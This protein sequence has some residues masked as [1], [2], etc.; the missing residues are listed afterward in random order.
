MLSSVA[1]ALVW[2]PRKVFGRMR[3]VECL[4]LRAMPVLATL[5]FVFAQL[6]PA[7]A[8][9]HAIERFGRFTPWSLGLFASTWA[10]AVLSVAGVVLAL[11][12]RNRQIRR[13]VWWHGFAASLILTAVALYL[14]YWG[15]IGQRSWA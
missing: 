12:F 13:L 15:L 14:G 5:S 9:E 6:L 10:F 11:R 7:L 2:V 4:S 1:F 3:S 8:S